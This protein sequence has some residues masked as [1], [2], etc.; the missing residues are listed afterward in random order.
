MIDTSL[1]DTHDVQTLTS[2]VKV[3]SA[4]RDLRVMSL[5]AG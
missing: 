3:V 5:T 1:T 4:A 2:T